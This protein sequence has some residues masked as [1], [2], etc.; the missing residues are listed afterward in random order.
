[1]EL[2]ETFLLLLFASL[3]HNQFIHCVLSFYIQVTASSAPMHSPSSFSSPLSCSSPKLKQIGCS[4]RLNHLFNSVRSGDLST[5]LSI[6]PSELRLA[7]DVNGST[8]LHW[9]AGS[10]SLPLTAFLS[11]PSVGCDISARQ[12]ASKG[13]GGRTPLHW[14]SR[15]GHA[16]VV[17]L[18]LASFRTLGAS[19]LA[20]TQ[21]LDK[22]A[23]DGTTAFCL[24]AWAASVPVLRLL[25]EEGADVHLPNKYGCNAALWWAQGLPAKEDFGVG[26]VGGRGEDAAA[27][28]SAKEDEALEAGAFLRTNARV[29]FGAVNSNGHSALHKAGQRGN[30]AV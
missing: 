6:P 11:S 13:F 21:L 23:C 15:N 28:A 7:L 29:D 8:L 1:M 30:L 4:A 3:T 9:S 12:Q 24:A 17:G 20:L 19:P 10:G 26:G 16:D 5:L 22:Q 25:F 27:G 14:A 18:L 2:R